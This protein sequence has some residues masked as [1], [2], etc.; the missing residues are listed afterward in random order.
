VARM[1]QLKNMMKECDSP[2]FDF[3]HHLYDTIILLGGRKDIADLLKK[4]MDYGLS[5]DDL[6]LLR[7]YNFNLAN[8]TKERLTQINSMGIRVSHE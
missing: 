3:R 4:S 1:M 8:A 5:G 2:D 6:K 7:N